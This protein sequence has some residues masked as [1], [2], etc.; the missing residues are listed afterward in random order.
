[1]KV[2]IIGGGAAG[3]FAAINLKYNYP[4]AHITIFEQK[5]ITLSKVKIS[6]GGRCN[7]TNNNRDLTKFLKNYPRG[8]NFLKKV[9]RMFN[10]MDTLNWF[11]SRGIEY[12]V[13]DDGCV[14][15]KSQKSQ[16]I[17]NLFLSEAERLDIRIELNKKLTSL[18]K[19]DEFCLSF[20]KNS[21]IVNHFD[22]VIITTGGSSL[23]ESYLYL[24][25]LGLKIEKPIPSLYS[26]ICKEPGLQ[27][28]KGI[29]VNDT[30]I[31]LRGTKIKTDGSLLFTHWGFSGP[32][33]LKLSAFGARNLYKENYHFAISI[34]WLGSLK[35]DEVFASLEKIKF[36]HKNKQLHNFRPFNLPERI[37]SFLLNRLALDKGKKW[38]D[39]GI[40]NLNKIMN[41][42]T[43]DIYTIS[44]KSAFH[45]EFVTC[46]GVSLKEVNAK[47]MGSK[48]IKGLYFAGEVLDVDGVTGGYN[49]QAAWTTAFIAAKLS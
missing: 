36:E 5:K 10:N 16:S 47:T 41:I 14:F 6:G 43:N 2:A 7:F 3:F 1:M 25:N 32:A 12:A 27:D 49:F 23:K 11:R 33:I 38:S 44:G 19:K 15:P 30:Q 18:E 42:L 26:F 35:Q 4:T 34:N 29:V 9:F 17:I 45:E 39:V 40:K 20:N 21:L 31:T 37:W 13:E 46:G 24:E 22:K 28:L 8:F 48:K